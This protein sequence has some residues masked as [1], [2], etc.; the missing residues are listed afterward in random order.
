MIW[1]E[2][3]K[4]GGFD[5]GTPDWSGAAAKVPDNEKVSN[6][7]IG[8][9][10][11]TPKPIVKVKAMP[12]PQQPPP[13]EP[14]PPPPP[15]KPQ[16]DPRVENNLKLLAAS[17]SELAKKK[18]EL[19]GRDLQFCVELGLAIGEQLACG[20]LNVHPEKVFEIVKEALG[21]FDEDD[22]TIV[23]LHPDIVAAFEEFKLMDTLTA[24]E[25]V[26]IK[27]DAAVSQLGCRVTADRKTVN[28]EIP[29]RLDRLK[30]LFA[31]EQGIHDTGGAD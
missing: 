6:I 14:E 1:F 18:Q 5:L 11:P 28:G 31:I 9:E 20:A 16:P 2:S 24:M 25:N 23:H 27:P 10:I 3:E 15:P 26:A 29:S 7:I 13:L 19:E 8:G 12:K 17:I 4:K 22:V 21:M 30:T